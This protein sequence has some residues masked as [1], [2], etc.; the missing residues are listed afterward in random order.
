M[1][2][3]NICVIRLYS[4]PENWML[5]I[6]NVTKLF[7]KYFWKKNCFC[8]PDLNSLKDANGD[9]GTFKAVVGIASEAVL[10]LIRQRNRKA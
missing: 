1:A 6:Y 4:L 2:R 5:N 7:S 10:A 9:N 8:Y 3:H